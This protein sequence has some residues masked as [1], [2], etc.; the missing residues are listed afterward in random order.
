MTYLVYLPY[1]FHGKKNIKNL[2]V[3][4]YFFYRTKLVDGTEVVQE[5]LAKPKT[6]Y[7]SPGQGPGLFGNFDEVNGNKPGLEG[8][9]VGHIDWISALTLCQASRWYVVSGSRDG[10]IKVWK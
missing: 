3:C 2:N 5:V 1:I 9:S 8:P 6:S 7:S 4:K 10:V